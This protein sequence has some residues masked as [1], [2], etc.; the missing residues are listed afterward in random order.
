MGS[1]MCIRDR[2]GSFES[3][4]TRTVYWKDA[5]S[6]QMQFGVNQ[7]GI[8]IL[9]NMAQP[10]PA[11]ERIPLHVTADVTCY[12]QGSDLVALSTR[13]GEIIWLRRDLPLGCDLYGDEELLFVTP[14]DSRDCQVLQL[15][16]G[17][18]LGQR[19]VLPVN[20]RMAVRGRLVL[21]WQSDKQGSG[22]QLRDTWEEEEIWS[23]QF[24]AGTFPWLVNSHE[25]AAVGTD[26]TMTVL[27]F[28]SGKQ[29]LQ[30]RVELPED[31]VG[32]AVFHDQGRYLVTTEKEDERPNLMNNPT[33]ATAVQVHGIVTSLDDRTGEVAWSRDCLL[34]TSPSP[35]DGLLSRMPSS[36]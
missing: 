21:T 14:P 35:R 34:Y 4:T 13:S 1:E 24:P 6:W 17:K 11:A 29:L 8:Q 20:Q 23:R 7:F 19:Q 27:E 36:A 12:Q 10:L 33:L 16:D 30:A 2:D 22:W 25:L 9:K 15:H 5:T 31:L 3:R 18:E 28:E 26:G 32:A